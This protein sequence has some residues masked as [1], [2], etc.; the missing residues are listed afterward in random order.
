[1]TI[2]NSLIPLITTYPTS[3]D[4]RPH[5]APEAALRERLAVLEA[6]GRRL[7]MAVESQREEGRG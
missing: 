3:D 4:A 5:D 7:E 6:R 1:M 2:T